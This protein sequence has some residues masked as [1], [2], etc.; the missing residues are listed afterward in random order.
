MRDLRPASTQGDGKAAT[1]DVFTTH[2]SPQVSSKME[3]TIDI[4]GHPWA[5]VPALPLP[6]SNGRWDL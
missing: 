2:L 6:G 1:G 4:H 3:G 5:S